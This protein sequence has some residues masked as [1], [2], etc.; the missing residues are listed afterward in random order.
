MLLFLPHRISAVV[1]PYIAGKTVVV[2]DEDIVT[3]SLLLDN[4]TSVPGDV[5]SWVAMVALFLLLLGH[6]YN[7]EYCHR[8]L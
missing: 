7:D 4:Y 1:V 5:S 2:P 3:S 6:L 8:L